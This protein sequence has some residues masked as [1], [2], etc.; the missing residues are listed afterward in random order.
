M[1]LD[2]SANGSERRFR[3]AL[4]GSLVHVAEIKNRCLMED[5]VR[6]PRSPVDK[7]AALCSAKRLANSLVA[8]DS[9]RPFSIS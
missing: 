1:K 5:N 6:P 2:A 3:I 7:L 9:A 8:P 4:V